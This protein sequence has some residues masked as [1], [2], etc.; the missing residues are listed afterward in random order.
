MACSSSISYTMER[1]M[2]WC[3]PFVLYVHS[4]QR[5]RYVGHDDVKHIHIYIYIMLHF[6]YRIAECIRYTPFII[7]MMM[8]IV[9]WAT[10]SFTARCLSLSLQRPDQYIYIYTKRLENRMKLFFNFRTNFSYLHLIYSYSYLR[11]YE[12]VCRLT[13]GQS[14]FKHRKISKKM[15]DAKIT[16]LCCNFSTHPIT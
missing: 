13:D 14:A 5:L 4:Q 11:P 15:S 7:F 16:K 8:A 1:A 6:D 12:S 9:A 10:A 2:H 3:M